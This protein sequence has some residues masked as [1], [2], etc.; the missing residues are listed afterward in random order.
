MP[1]AHHGWRDAAAVASFLAHRPVDPAP[2]FV[3]L[4]GCGTSGNQTSHLGISGRLDGADVEIDTML[5]DRWA[6]RPGLEQRD[7]IAQTVWHD[8]FA[9]DDIVSLPLEVRID[10]ADRVITVDGEEQTFSGVRIAG[11]SRWSGS[12]FVGDLLIRVTVTEPAVVRAIVSTD[13]D[14]LDEFPPETRRG[15]R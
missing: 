14:G 8:L 6:R 4:G 10:S 2:D 9:D 5:S 13:G 11:T 7:R 1:R 12:C 15:D 3:W